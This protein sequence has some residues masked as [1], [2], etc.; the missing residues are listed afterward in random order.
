MNENAVR[1]EKMEVS[2]VAKRFGKKE[3]LRGVS[4]SAAPGEC[5]GILG[6]NG[7]GKSTLF[8]ILAGVL[9]ADGGSFRYRGADL[10]RRR[11]ALADVVGYV[12]QKDPL[13]GDLN[14]RDHLMLWYTK[15]ERDASLK[16]GILQKLGIASFWKTPVARMSGGM[17]KRLS[18]AIALSGRKPI[19]LLDEPTGDLDLCG[20]EE[21]R[22]YVRWYCGQGGIVLLATHEA[23]DFK[24]CDRYYLLRDGVLTPYDYDGDTARLMEQL[25]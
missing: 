1:L 10:L 8:S 19:L 22:S 14:A 16:N 7:S 3:V 2:G 15:E 25:Q 11:G 20:K 4:F 13:M 21:I 23:E 6:K 9:R 12:P 18:L 17:K 5:V 24:L